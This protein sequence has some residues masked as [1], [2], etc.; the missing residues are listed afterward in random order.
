MSSIT[1]FT[2]S[3]Y[4]D[5]INS[6]RERIN[7]IDVLIDKAILLLAENIEGAGGNISS[8]EL[9]DGQIHI[10]TA[11]R[12]IDDIENGIKSLERIKQLYTNRLF[13]RSSVLRDKRTY[14]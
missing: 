3:S 5:S 10:K 14:R 4:L 8:Y 1:E 2:I 7:A 9:D 13:G 11:Y 6:L 12:S